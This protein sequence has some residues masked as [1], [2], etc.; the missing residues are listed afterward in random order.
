MMGSKHIRFPVETAG[1]IATARI[2][3]LGFSLTNFEN[4]QVSVHSLVPFET[5][6]AII[7]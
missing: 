1:A 3:Q 4:L 6:N 7:S 5:S 2:N